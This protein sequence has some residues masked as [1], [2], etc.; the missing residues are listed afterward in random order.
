M[1]I[2]LNRVPKVRC[3][4]VR[5]VGKIAFRETGWSGWPPGNSHWREC[6]RSDSS[7]V[8]D[9]RVGRSLRPLPHRIRITFLGLS[10][11][12]QLELGH[13]GDA[14]PG[15][16]HGGQQG[17]MAEVARCFEPVHRWSAIFPDVFG[18]KLIRR[19]AKMLVCV[20]TVVNGKVYL[21]TFSNQ[22]NVYGLHPCSKFPGACGK[23]LPLRIAVR[24]AG[25][26][27]TPFPKL[28]LKRTVLLKDF[29]AL[30]LSDRLNDFLVVFGIG[31]AVRS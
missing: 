8:G 17:A 2:E 18:A 26:A 1:G 31:S 28:L 27:G 9:S 12:S 11:S 15:G 7:S 5:Q 30:P 22:L 16:I 25:G 10:M 6:D 4:F 14:D 24:R 19:F 29:R 20:P 23:D 13:F 3:D 21:A